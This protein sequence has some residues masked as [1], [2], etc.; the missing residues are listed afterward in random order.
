MPNYKPIASN[1]KY[2]SNNTRSIGQLLKSQLS[3]IINQ[4]HFMFGLIFLQVDSLEVHVFYK[5]L[6]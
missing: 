5:Y 2:Y 3:K 1:A 6:F 4:G